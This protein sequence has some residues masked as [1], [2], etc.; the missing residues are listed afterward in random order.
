MSGIVASDS[1]VC[2]TKRVIKKEMRGCSSQNSLF[3]ST[4]RWGLRAVE[5]KVAGY[6]WSPK[7][8]RLAKS[9]SLSFKDVVGEEQGWQDYIPKRLSLSETSLQCSALSLPFIEVNIHWLHQQTQSRS[10]HTGCRELSISCKRLWEKQQIQKHKLP[11]LSFVSLPISIPSLQ[12]LYDSTATN[13]LAVHPPWND[14]L[15]L[16]PL[17][18]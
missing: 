11:N 7:C 12:C 4:Y 5:S 8:P 18:E 1:H 10:L 16:S 2:W 15:N 3:N 13:K 9:L 14:F 6:F 17:S